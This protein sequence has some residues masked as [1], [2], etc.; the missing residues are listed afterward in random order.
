MRYEEL[1]AKKKVPLTFALFSVLLLIIGNINFVL[2][3]QTLV[4]QKNLA[5]QLFIENKLC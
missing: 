2:L 3:H 1:E 4:N 5:S